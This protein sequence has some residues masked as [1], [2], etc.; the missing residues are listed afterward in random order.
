MTRLRFTLA[1]LIAF[2]LFIGFGFAALRNAD[3]LWASA[4]FSLAILT[5]SVA[6]AGA[7][8]REEATRMPW[9]GFA[10]AGG[11]RLL[12][13][14]LTSSTVGHLNGPPYP[15]VYRLGPY[16]NPEAWVGG[17][18]LIA[19]TQVSHSLDVILL[20]CFG[21]VIGRFLAAKDE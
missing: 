21:A 8:S 16:I 19:Y 5:V 7:W 15:L 2:V 10:I 6:L 18:L 17:P 11:L 14:L 1:Q 12:V 13:W 20:G 9:A 3:G 4:A